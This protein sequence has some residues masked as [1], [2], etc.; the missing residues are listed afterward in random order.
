MSSRDSGDYLADEVRAHEAKVK[1]IREGHEAA[2]QEVRDKIKEMKKA[3]LA[4]ESQHALEISA[5]MQA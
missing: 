1:A 5:A 2:M 4:V 3:T